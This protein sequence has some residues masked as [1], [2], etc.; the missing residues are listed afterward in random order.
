MLRTLWATALFRCDETRAGAMQADRFDDIEGRAP[1]VERLQDRATLDLGPV[2]GP[3]AA[4]APHARAPRMRDS[5]TH[6]GARP[7]S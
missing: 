5:R 6:R 4:G 1:R 2:Y 3:G 7:W